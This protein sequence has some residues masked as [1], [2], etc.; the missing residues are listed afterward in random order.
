MLPRFLARMVSESNSGIPNMARTEQA[1][2]NADPNRSNDPCVALAS[3][4]NESTPFYWESEG[5]R[6]PSS[7]PIAIPALPEHVVYYRPVYYSGSA[8]VGRG[9]MQVASIR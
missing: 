2:S 6:P 4:I 1:D 3:T 7:G 5:Q 8:I 9:Q